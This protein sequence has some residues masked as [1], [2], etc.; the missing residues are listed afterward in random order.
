MKKALALAGTVALTLLFTTPTLAQHGGPAGGQA[1]TPPAQ[2]QAQMPMCAMMGG[3]QQGAGGGGMMG[4]MASMD[5]ARM[6][7][8][9]EMMKSMGEI[10]MKHGKMMEKSAR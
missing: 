6:R 10:M 1:A 7:M 9:G 2:G 8:Q 3:M 4:M 5:P